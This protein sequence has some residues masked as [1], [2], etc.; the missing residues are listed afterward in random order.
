MRLQD[1]RPVVLAEKLLDE[2]AVGGRQH[3]VRETPD[4]FAYRQ[5]RKTTLAVLR[6]VAGQLA[7]RRGRRR[8]GT[9]VEN[10]IEIIREQMVLFLPLLGDHRLRGSAE[11]FDV[12]FGAGPDELS[13]QRAVGH[14]SFTTSSPLRVA[15][16][17]RHRNMQ[18]FDRERQSSSESAAV[19]CGEVES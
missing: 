12:A 4:R 9:S 7:H 10:G 3:D 16:L 19:T 13:Q 14:G 11:G 8:P 18:R 6:D 17:G 1:L 15:L 2:R 5:Q